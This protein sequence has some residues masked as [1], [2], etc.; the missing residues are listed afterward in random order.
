MSGL[1]CSVVSMKLKRTQTINL[2]LQRE[3]GTT[4]FENAQLLGDAWIDHKY[5][6]E[7]SRSAA[8]PLMQL[9]RG[10][11]VYFEPK[12][13]VEKSQ[14]YLDLMS[15]LRLRQQEKEYQE[16]IGR[17]EEQTVIKPGTIEAKALKEEVTTIFNITI[18]VVA[19]AWAIWK[20]TPYWSVQSRTLACL[21]GS[22]L[23]LVAEVVVYLGY[24]RRVND[25]RNTAKVLKE[26]RKIIQTLPIDPVESIEE[27]EVLKTE[28]KTTQADVRRRY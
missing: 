10:T 25:A 8:I 21:F 23:I 7:L 1:R 5:L 12:P 13:V 27:E 20:W 2:A 4:P 3:A 15:E 6:I 24:R 19:V 16:L 17:N 18:S 11:S 26:K 9:V 14:E 22:I 28:S